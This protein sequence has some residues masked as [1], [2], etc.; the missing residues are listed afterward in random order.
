MIGYPRL[1]GIRITTLAA[2]VSLGLTGL[3][4]VGTS[5]AFA[6]ET[7]HATVDSLTL[8]CR[9]SSLLS[10]ATGNGLVVAGMQ[11]RAGRGSVVQGISGSDGRGISG[12]DGRGISGSDGRGISGSD[13]RGISG[14]DGRSII[15]EARTG[16]AG[17]VERIEISSAGSEVTV[18][19]QRFTVSIDLSGC[20]DVGDYVVAG[21]TESHDLVALVAVGSMYVPGESQVWVRGSVTEANESVGTLNVGALEV[22]YTPHLGSDSGYRPSVGSLVEISG[23]QPVPQGA[24]ILGISG[25]DGR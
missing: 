24:V 4:S 15:A 3:T 14:S 1:E 12:S 11:S 22:D 17:P 21:A 7:N 6:A 10:V 23:T 8:V 18:L 13:G 2:A 25:S 20:V 19:G 5:H 9:D 16:A